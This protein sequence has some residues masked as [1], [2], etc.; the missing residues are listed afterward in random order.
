MKRA[1]SYLRFSEPRQ[2]WGDSERRQ[3]K[4]TED[5]CR[6]KGLTLDESLRLTDRG[7]SAHHSA[8]AETGRLGVFLDE[9]KA[10]RVPSGSTLIIENLD[11]LSRD[12]TLKALNLFT[13]IL[14]AGLTIVT[15]SPEREYT[16][17]TANA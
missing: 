1:F 12:Q 2:Q 14:E 17:A 7:V 5:Y 3:V 15:L 8:N 6:R 13:C 4:L 10:G 11:R 9:V 16:Y